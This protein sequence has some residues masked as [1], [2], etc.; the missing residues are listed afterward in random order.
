MKPNLFSFRKTCTVTF[1]IFIAARV[2]APNQYPPSLQDQLAI[3]ISFFTLSSPKLKAALLVSVVFERACVCASIE[4]KECGSC[5]LSGMGG[6]A[7]TDNWSRCQRVASL[8]RSL[9][10][11]VPKNT[12]LR[13]NNGWSHISYYYCKCCVTAGGSKGQ[14]P[15][16]I[17]NAS[18]RTESERERH[19]GEEEKWKASEA[20]RQKMKLLFTRQLHLNMYCRARDV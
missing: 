13:L 2:E 1:E 4:L 7:E 9:N 16:Q 11:Q 19:R 5:T 8:A 20:D 3:H 15:H 10:F 17:I 6:T 18:C 12:W 14:I